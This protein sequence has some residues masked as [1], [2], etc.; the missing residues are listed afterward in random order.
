MLL[1]AARMSLTLMETDLAGST[2]RARD[3]LQ[4]VPGDFDQEVARLR[5]GAQGKPP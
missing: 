3:A 5:K 2:E 1:A 4:G